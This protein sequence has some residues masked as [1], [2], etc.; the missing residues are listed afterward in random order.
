MRYN[1]LFNQD[2]TW[3]MDDAFCQR[4]NERL[5]DFDLASHDADQYKRYR[6]LY[7][8]FI[9]T[10]FKYPD[11]LEDIK[12]RFKAIRNKFNT[13]SPSKD[14]RTLAQ[15][16]NIVFSQVETD[17]DELA[18]TIINLLYEKDLIYLKRKT[19]NPEQEFENDYK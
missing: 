13:Y 15:H 3:N 19:T 16:Q 8:I 4:I 5:N 17:I 6:V 14:R 1:A 10:H 18:F 2:K 9:D 11:E 12:Q 7:S